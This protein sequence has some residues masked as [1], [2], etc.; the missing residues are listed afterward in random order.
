MGTKL[1]LPRQGGADKYPQSM[2]W[3]K[4]RKQ[5]IL[6]YTPVLLYKSG[7]KGGIHFTD[8]L[9]YTGSP[10]TTNTTEVRALRWK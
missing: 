8:M 10:E 4:D 1:D 7:V 5:F 3:I 9:S 6:L 2:F